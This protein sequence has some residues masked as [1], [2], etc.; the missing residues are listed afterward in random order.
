ME[1]LA[2]LVDADWSRLGEPSRRSVRFAFADVLG[3]ALSAVADPPYRVLAGYL[4][5]TGA[6][7]VPLPGAGTVSTRHAAIGW[8]MLAHARDYDDVS[9][10][11]HGHP[12]AVLVPAILALGY[13]ERVSGADLVDA[14]LSGYEA[15]GRVGAAAADVQRARGWHT[16]ATIG[17]LGATV[18]AARILGLPRPKVVHALGIAT[19]MASGVQAN[20]GSMTKPLHAGW[21]AGNAVT[22]AELAAAG[23]E[24]GPE[25]LTSDASYLQ[26]FGGTWPP[27]DAGPPHID[28]G[29][30]FKPYPCCGS[31]TGLVDCALELHADRAGAEIT[32]VTCEM[33]PQMSRTLRYTDPARGDQARFSAEFCVAQ[34]LTGGVL[35]ER[36]F[37]AGFAARYDAVRPL[38]RKVTRVLAGEAPPGAKDVAVTVRLAD[39]RELRAASAAPKGHPANPMPAAELK[40]K[41]CACTEDVL[42][43]GRGD[44]IFGRLSRIDHEPA[45]DTLVDDLLTGWSTT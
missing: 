5:D 37:R 36:C 9:E 18:A 13:R 3:V 38:M 44:A 10:V 25:A 40:A 29:I 14:Y 26:V 4:R 24:A 45:A 30:R 7:P 2:D 23:F 17:V 15:I 8:G 28:A 41:F 32:A 39:G 16:T 6:G 27:A 11:L 19:S 22:A 42:P 12:S 43:A 21:A 34:A 31:A 35:T 33:V 20:F 1:S